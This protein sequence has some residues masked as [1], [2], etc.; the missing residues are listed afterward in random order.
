VSVVNETDVRSIRFGGIDSQ[1]SRVSGPASPVL[2]LD[3]IPIGQETQQILIGVVAPQFLE[4][5]QIGV[6]QK[7]SSSSSFG[8]VAVCFGGG[9]SSSFVVVVAAIAPNRRRL[10]D[11]S[12]IFEQ[13]LT[14]PV[15]LE[16]Q[17]RM[18][19]KAVQLGHV[20]RGVNGGPPEGGASRQLR[21]ERRSGG[22]FA[23]AMVD[24][25]GGGRTRPALAA[26][27]A[28]APGSSAVVGGVDGGSPSSGGVGVGVGVAVGVAVAGDAAM[29][30]VDAAVGGGGGPP[31]PRTTAGVR[32]AGGIHGHHHR[33]RR[34]RRRRGIPPPST[35]FR[36]QF[37]LLL[38]VFRSEPPPRLSVVVPI[39]VSV[40]DRA[41]LS[42][43]FFLLLA[44]RPFPF[45]AATPTETPARR[46]DKS[47][48]SRLLVLF[49]G[50]AVVVGDAVDVVRRAGPGPRPAPGGS[51]GRGRRG[52]DAAGERA[53]AG[54]GGV[55]VS[56]DG[57]WTTG[58]G[59]RAR[60]ATGG[61]GIR[62]GVGVNVGR[63]EM[64]MT[65]FDVRG[66]RRRGAR[67]VVNWL[68]YPGHARLLT[69]VWM[70]GWKIGLGWNK[71]WDWIEL[72]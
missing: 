35:S 56:R 14:R 39:S 62:I 33:R 15:R 5:P 59:A 50:I 13:E 51:G 1:Q 45:A 70:I 32:S 42:S 63:A 17:P 3:L 38:L 67:F 28:S 44:F 68:G 60:A 43:C 7:V 12:M 57:D 20:V 58:A 11:E 49:A 47:P 23:F 54:T 55:V 18:P 65:A 4:G 37:L 22:V 10:D 71:Q 31:P 66:G 25:G 8:A 21:Q 52:D 26:G 2:R 48:P 41:A 29:V 53:V 36:A 9:S 46:N 30:V 61:I 72:Q 64:R 40:D 6:E 34:R 19:Q 27:A 69:I 16:P 24:G